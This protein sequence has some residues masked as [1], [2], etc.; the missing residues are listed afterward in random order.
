LFIW[1]DSTQNNIYDIGETILAPA[2]SSLGTSMNK[3]SLAS[4]S[5]KYIGMAWCAG[6]QS[7]SGSTLA[8]D[9]SSM[10]DIAQTDS[11]TADITAYAVQQRNNTSFE[12]SSVNLE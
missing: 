1:E 6:T 8:C 10:G 11:F 9:G 2:N 5:T 12:C 3:L 7:L 4:A